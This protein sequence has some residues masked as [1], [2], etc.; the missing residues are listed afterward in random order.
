M[1]S[2]SLCW[3][4]ST[5]NERGQWMFLP[6]LL[7]RYQSNQICLWLPAGIRYFLIIL[8][9]SSSNSNLILTE[10]KKSNSTKFSG[11]SCSQ[12]SSTPAGWR[13]SSASHCKH[14]PA[15]Q[16]CT[17]QTKTHFLP[18]T[19]TTK[20]VQQQHSSSVRALLNVRGWTL[21]LKTYK[22]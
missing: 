12:P 21:T 16:S 15:S 14:H 20:A 3:W 6:L 8:N 13:Q 10:K 7:R 19:D 17:W 18:W 5:E 22:P 1:C 2:K 11:R 4:A 9:L